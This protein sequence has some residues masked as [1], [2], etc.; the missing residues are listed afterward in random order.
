M[1]ELLK[2]VLLRAQ[3]TAGEKPRPSEL[4]NVLLQLFKPDHEQAVKALLD[5]A[6]ELIDE[7]LTQGKEDSVFVEPSFQNTFNNDLN[8]FLK[9]EQL[10]KNE[11]ATPHLR[12][13]IQDCR[14]TM[15]RAMSV[16]AVV[17]VCP[18]AGERANGLTG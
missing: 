3:L 1:T 5:S 2:D 17:L 14:R 13:L 7:Y 9:W 18:F 15:G 16:K 10:G 6:I 12:S 11:E 4:T 8:S